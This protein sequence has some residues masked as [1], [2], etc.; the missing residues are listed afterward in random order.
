MKWGIIVDGVSVSIPMNYQNICI[1]CFKEEIWKLTKTK[2][3]LWW[4]CFLTDIWKLTIR[5][6]IWQAP[7]FF[8]RIRTKWAIF[9]KDLH[10][11]CQ[12]LFSLLQWFQ[13]RWSKCEK[14]TDGWTTDDGCQVMAIADIDDHFRQVS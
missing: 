1:C 3:C 13:R 2:N 5:N 4:Q 8:W 10:H 14:L 7:M 12:D 9:V 11:S 6:N